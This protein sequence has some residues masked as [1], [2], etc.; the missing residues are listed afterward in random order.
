MFG[1]GFGRDW[2]R[3]APTALVVGVAITVKTVLHGELHAN[4]KRA[5]LRRSIDEN[6]F[7]RCQPFDGTAEGLERTR[8]Q[9]AFL[10]P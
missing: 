2:Q 1:S 8:Y 6:H 5:R 9:A 10:A 4:R 3:R 7:T